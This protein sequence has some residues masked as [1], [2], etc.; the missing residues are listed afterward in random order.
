LCF[1]TFSGRCY[2]PSLAPA[3]FARFCL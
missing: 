1:E 3:T 2:R